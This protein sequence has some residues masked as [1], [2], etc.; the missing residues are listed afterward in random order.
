MQVLC[1]GAHCD[2]IEIGCGGSLL[3]MVKG[4]GGIHVKWVV[5][6]SNSK[7]KVEAQKAAEDFLRNVKNKE[8]VILDFKDGF[9]PHSGSEVKA[10]FEKLKENFSPD[11][12]FTHYSKD[13]HQDHR[14]IN[15]LTW[16]TFRNHYILEYE[17]PKYDG[18]MG[19]PST[20]IPIDQDMVNEKIRLIEK[21]Y[22]TQAGKQWFDDETFRAI[23]RI[24]GMES[25]SE[26][27]YAEGFYTRK[28]VLKV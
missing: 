2:D 25:V 6:T 19:S 16:N 1:L 28:T 26:T 3:Q 18:D 9:L 14:L 7:R 4:G 20:Y 15:E 22:P 10:Y 17:I 5:F 12:I 21:N 24:R 27:K 23:M 13:A 11:L 8:I